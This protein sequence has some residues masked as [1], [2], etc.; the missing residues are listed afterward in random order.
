MTD[1]YLVMSRVT[2][3][4][5]SHHHTDI[6]YRK[7]DHA[8]VLKCSCFLWGVITRP[9]PNLVMSLSYHAPP[10]IGC[11]PHFSTHVNSTCV[12]AVR[13]PC[14][15][16]PWDSTSLWC[17]KRFTSCMGSTRHPYGSHMGILRGPYG[18][19]MI[20]EPVTTPVR[21]RTEPIQYPCGL[22][23]SY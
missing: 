17:L 20:C 21:T 8:E 14:G 1:Y 9:C 2:I 10:H 19:R 12:G 23:C 16:R 6:V 18:V 4:L 13:V 15:Y 5:G 3:K 7:L 11:F 22:S